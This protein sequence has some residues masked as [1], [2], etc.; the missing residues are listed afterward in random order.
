MAASV[1]GVLRLRLSAADLSRTVVRSVPAVMTEM[2][3]A[4]MLLHRAN[5]PARLRWWLARTRASLRPVMRPFL[6]LT[7]GGEAAPDFLTPTGAGADFDTELDKVLATPSERASAQVRT[8]RRAGLLPDRADDAVAMPRL[9][10]AMRAFYQVAVRPYWQEFADA[11]HA[12]R[13][14]RGRALADRGIE[15]VLRGLSPYLHWQTR[16]LS[17]ECAA[18]RDVELCAAGRGVALVPS[19]LAWG[20]AVLDV[21]SAPIELWYPISIERPPPPV[22]ESLSKLLGRTRAAVLVAVGAGRSTTELADHLRVSVASA[23]QHTAVL[24]AAGLISTRRNGQ[25][26]VHNLTPLGEQLLAHDTGEP[27]GIG[28]RRLATSVHAHRH[29]VG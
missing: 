10:V 4:G 17:Y 11:I 29:H 7:A 26:V 1:E 3:A 28:E 20:P 22:A 14:A 12:D 15:H 25:A 9:A 2:A 13:A 23:S 19:Y 21:G 24:R 6:D 27:G 16:T 18:G 8:L 5:P